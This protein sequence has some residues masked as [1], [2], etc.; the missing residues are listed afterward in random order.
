MFVPGIREVILS[1]GE[2][3]G[4]FVITADAVVPIRLHLGSLTAD[5]REILADGCLMNY[6]KNRR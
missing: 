5:E 6:Y 3:V 1:G 4:A 2:E